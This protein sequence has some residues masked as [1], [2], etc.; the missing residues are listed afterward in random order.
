[1]VRWFKGNAQFDA[2]VRKNFKED[3]GRLDKG[4]YKEWE[5]DHDG[6]LALIL[7]CDQLSRFCYRQE[8]EAFAFDSIALKLAKSITSD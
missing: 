5:K 2:L 6:K 3:F 8:K 1:M 4:K 7:L